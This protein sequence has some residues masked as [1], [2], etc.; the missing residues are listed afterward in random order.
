MNRGAKNRRR[1]AR[2]VRRAIERFSN[3]L[4]VSFFE[5]LEQPSAF[6]GL[7]SLSCMPSADFE[8]VIE[9]PPLPLERVGGQGTGER[10]PEE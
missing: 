4:G 6:I 5:R 3:V 7:L 8:F 1:K 9:V 2:L 10:S